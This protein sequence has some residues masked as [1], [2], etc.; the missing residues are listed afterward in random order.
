MYRGE[1]RDEIIN[2]LEVR[3]FTEPQ[4]E[5]K[6]QMDGKKSDYV[7]IN[8]K[9]AIKEI[10]PKLDFTLPGF[11]HRT[12]GIIVAPGSTGKSIFSLQLAISVCLGRDVFGIFDGEQIT[13]GRVVI[14]NVEDP[15][16]IIENR[17]HQFSDMLSEED[18][19]ILDANL[20]IIPAS[21]RNLAILEKAEF[22]RLNKTKDYIDLVSR[23]AERGAR[24]V[25]IDTLNRMAGGADE[26]DN[27]AAGQLLNA[28]EWLNHQV[29]CST[30]IVHHTNKSS[31]LNGNGSEQQAARG[32]S[33]LT[34]N[35]RWQLN[36]STMS[37]ADAESMGVPE[38]D[39]RKWVRLDFAKVNY[40]APRNFK[41]LNRGATGTLHGD[42]GEPDMHVVTPTKKRKSL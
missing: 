5:S 28:V 1:Y 22:N 20:D 40:G 30:L 11:L 31:T 4:E 2:G 32:A 23:I 12:A 13:Q 6:K 14:I 9:R 37:K 26:N 3:T 15:R 27:A 38:N 7:R 10:P 34:D 18:I 33:A 35:A 24:L 41:W 17:I 16:E 42:R 19:D 39:R 29:N 21:G 36:L 8:I 25:I